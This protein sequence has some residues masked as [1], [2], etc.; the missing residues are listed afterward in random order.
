MPRG[1]VSFEQES[2]FQVFGL[3]YTCAT[4]KVDLSPR[5]RL[6]LRNTLVF[7]EEHD[8]ESNTMQ[9]VRR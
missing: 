7:L 2:E 3:W 9:K 4:L 6:I 8:T 1:Q 5:T